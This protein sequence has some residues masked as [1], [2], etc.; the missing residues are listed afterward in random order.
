MATIKEIL[1]ETKNFLLYVLKNIGILLL[2]ILFIILIALFMFGNFGS[3][4]G[5]YNDFGDNL[6]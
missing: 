4:M 5:R 6:L 3:P 1:V 2:Y